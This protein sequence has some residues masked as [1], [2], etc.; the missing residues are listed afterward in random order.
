M[1]IILFVSIYIPD[2]FKSRLWR[3]WEYRLLFRLGKARY[4]FEM[5]YSIIKVLMS[6]FIHCERRSRSTVNTDKPRAA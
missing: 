3:L 4:G 2:R 1:I 6:N 5:E